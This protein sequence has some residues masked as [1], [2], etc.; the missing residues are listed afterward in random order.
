M[1]F[2]RLDLNLLVALDALLSERSV[3]LA[4]DRIFLSQSATSSALGRLRDYFGDELLVMK[5]RQMVLT[6]RAESLVE[7]VRA[8]LE[9]IRTSIAIPPPFDP[10]TSDRTIRIV[11][12]DY[13]TDVLLASAISEI[14][15]GAPN[16]RFEVIPIEDS[17][18]E[19]LERGFVD[20]LITIDYGI[21][22]DHPSQIL[23]EDDYVVIGW[24]DNPA[25]AEPMTLDRYLDLGHVTARFGRG[26]VSAFEDWFVRRQKRQ[27]R[28]EIVAPNFMTQA[29]FILGT[30]RIGTVQR[31]LA[32]RMAEYLPI[33]MR[34][35][36]LQIPPIREA[37][38]WHISSNNDPAIRWVVERLAAYVHQPG[39]L[40]G[41]V[42]MLDEA[43]LGGMS[44]EE[45]TAGF[46]DHAKS[47]RRQSN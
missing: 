32:V 26:R 45:L 13:V 11:A 1:R 43:R 41:D 37:I 20:L 46:T 12:S 7:P 17:M 19:N 23:F 14:Q 40:A 28:I 6:A 18:I 33:V 5:G 10:A 44:R 9:Q 4:A 47:P 22:P 16:M 29:G 3:S 2:E 27:R 31:R 15:S 39:M 38:Q 34:E 21:S 8:V 36:P 30:N 35:L 25:M 24:A 42:I